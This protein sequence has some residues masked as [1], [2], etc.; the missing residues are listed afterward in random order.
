MHVKRHLFG[1]LKA[2]SRMEALLLWGPRQVGKTTLLDLFP[3]GSR[4]FLDDLGLR[5]RAQADPALFLDGATLP[6]LIDEAQYAPNIFPEIKKR[7]DHSRRENLRAGGD[8]ASKTS[9]YLTGSNKMLIDDQVRESLAGRCSTFVLHGLSLAEI[10]E[11]S[12]E[13][14]VK[15][16]MFRGAMPE[17]YKRSD[18]NP[19]DYY[20]DYVRSYV[21]KDVALTAGVTK[22]DSFNDVLRLLAAR[23]GQFL[24]VS[25]I[26]NTAGVDQKTV[27]SWIG[28]LE[29]NGICSLVEPFHTNLSKRVVKM[30]KFYFM[31]TGLCARLQSQ[32]SEDSLWNSSQ[33]GGLFE[34]LVYSELVKTRDN[35]LLDWKIFTWRTKEK[36]EIDFIIQ[37]GDQIICVEAKL[38][39]HN[40]KS[41]DLDREALKVFPKQTKKILAFAGTETIALDR[42]ATVAVPVIEIGTY[43]RNTMAQLRQTEQ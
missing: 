26:A 4:M 7:I 40:V 24:N 30:P 41:F 21:E 27:Q 28:L 22:L 16:L 9:Y 25:E 31:D 29:R 1:T 39:H 14:P 2:A 23:T 20:N 8:Q 13:L 15:T 5:E 19:Y 11:A 10:K 36:N 17:L 12:P 34:T 43:L 35:F 38:A 42:G 6:C 37:S 33:A 3:L 32:A 18:L